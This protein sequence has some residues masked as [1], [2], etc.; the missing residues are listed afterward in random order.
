MASGIFYDDD[1]NDITM[2]VADAIAA[3]DLDDDDAAAFL[4]RTDRADP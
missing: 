1:G 4:K 3:G 2:A